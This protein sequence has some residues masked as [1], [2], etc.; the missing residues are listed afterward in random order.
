VKLIKIIEMCLNKTYSKVN[1]GIIQSLL[2]VDINKDI[3]CLHY[4]L[5]F[6]LEYARREVQEDHLALE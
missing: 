3:L 2:G 5:T 6:A 1:A 4:F